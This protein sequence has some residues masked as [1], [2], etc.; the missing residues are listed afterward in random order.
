MKLG[1]EGM[2]RLGKTL[3]IQEHSTACTSGFLCSIIV[4]A[5]WVFGTGRRFLVVMLML[6][7][8]EAPDG[9]TIGSGESSDPSPHQKLRSSPV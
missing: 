2:T 6:E 4:D 7:G 1:K 8:C 3:G 5:A 9:K